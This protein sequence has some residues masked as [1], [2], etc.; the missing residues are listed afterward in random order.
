MG[1]QSSSPY[2]G[3]PVPGQVDP[4]Q[5][6]QI[7]S[8]S[9]AYG[10]LP[11]TAYDTL[12]QQG[13][14]TF[15][16][17][18]DTLEV[19]QRFKKKT[20]VDLFSLKGSDFSST[21]L[22]LMAG[23]EIAG[24]FKA[25]PS[26][27]SFYHSLKIRFRGITEPASDYAYDYYFK[28]PETVEDKAKAAESGQKTDAQVAADAAKDAKDA[29]AK[30]DQTFFEW[31]FGSDT[32]DT[33]TTTSTDTTTTTSTGTGTTTVTGTDASA[34]A[35]P[36]SAAANAGAS[37]ALSSMGSSLASTA[38]QFVPLST[39]APAPNAVSTATP[40][41]GTPAPADT[42]SSLTTASTAAPAPAPAAATS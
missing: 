23:R 32:T 3:N 30:K 10:D 34:S 38:S 26:K 9:L 2:R 1:N 18:A 40:A 36:G 7:G 37:S 27:Y 25:P 14:I 5:N 41:T 12:D 21:L 42:T 17:N 11:G 33:T 4:P 29:K 6:N 8:A 16:D 15:G 19:V 35:T 28:D 39:P 13:R 22:A 24:K 31:L 20:G